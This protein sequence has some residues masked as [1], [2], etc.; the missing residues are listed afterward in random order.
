MRYRILG[1]V[2]LTL[3][4]T[5]D[6]NPD[7]SLE[8]HS[9]REIADINILLIRHIPLGY[10]PFKGNGSPSDPRKFDTTDMPYAPRLSPLKKPGTRCGSKKIWHRRD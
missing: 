4:C 5:Q 10:Y 6:I 9:T 2:K 7:I 1:I 8:P 3:K